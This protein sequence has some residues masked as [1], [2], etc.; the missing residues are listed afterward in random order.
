MNKKVIFVPL[1]PRHRARKTL[2]SNPPKHIK[3]IIGKEEIKNT[4]V[5][6]IEKHNGFFNKIRDF[7]H[8][9]LKKI[10]SQFQFPNIEIKLP[11]RKFYFDYYLKHGSLIL[12]NKKFI[13]HQ[14]EYIISLFNTKGRKLNSRLSLILLK[15]ILLSNR[16]KY[17]FCMSEASKESAI[18]IL[19]IPKKKQ[20]KFQVIYPTVYPIKYKKDSNDNIVRLLYLS[21]THIFGNSFY[22]KGGKLVLQAFE[23][24]KKKYDNIELVFNG[25]IPPEFKR[26]FEKISSIKF[27]A[28]IPYE[29]VI[30]FYKKADIFLFPTYGDNFGFTFIEAM[31][32]GLPIICINNH[33][34]SP[35]LV[36]N[37][38]TGFLVDTSFKFLKYPFG[39]INYDWIEKWK[40][41]IKKED[42]LVGL[43]NLVEKLKILI[44]NKELREKFGNNGRNRLIDGELSIKARNRKL[45]LLF[46]H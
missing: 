19:N 42:D 7:S 29:K 17:I 36:L 38:E 41:V 10:F 28:D 22:W 33:F 14:L 23:K 27:Y 34:A 13:V 6:P 25:Y 9:I 44:Q 18:K 43:N 26:H 2:L 16:C 1:K 35:E 32:Y 11:D 24:L 30:D 4:K 39:I 5:E 46:K 8:I 31:G 21:R 15:T 20:E 3:Y 37:N 12:S 40:N 45:N